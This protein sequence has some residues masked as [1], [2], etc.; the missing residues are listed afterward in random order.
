M[1]HL[2]ELRRYAWFVDS[3]SVFSR[4]CAEV[5]GEGFAL[6]PY[7]KEHL[8]AFTGRDKPLYKLCQA[9]SYVQTT[10]RWLDSQGLA[11]R[12]FN[13]RALS[14]TQNGFESLAAKYF[15]P[16]PYIHLRVLKLRYRKIAII[17]ITASTV[18]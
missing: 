7:I 6:S 14:I 17:T 12:P 13:T 8:P 4:V 1:A 10:L 18:G 9:A 5:S 15:R 11:G 16:G 2:D 3:R